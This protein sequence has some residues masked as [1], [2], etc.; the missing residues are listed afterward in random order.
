M[1]KPPFE[2]GDLE[3]TSVL[4]VYKQGLQCN[5]PNYF[6][7]PQAENCLVWDYTPRDRVHV[8]VRHHVTCPVARLRPPCLCAGKQALPA[9]K[10]EVEKF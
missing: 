3:I 7:W 8:H 5:C 10:D 9:V 1:L 4:G 2:P 6:T